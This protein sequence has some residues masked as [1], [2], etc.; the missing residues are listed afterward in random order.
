MKFLPYLLLFLSRAS[1]S[2][3]SEFFNSHYT[4]LLSRRLIS[5]HD[6]IIHQRFDEKTYYSNDENTAPIPIGTNPTSAIVSPTNNTLQFDSILSLGIINNSSN[7]SLTAD[8]A[9]LTAAVGRPTFF[10]NGMEGICVGKLVLAQRGTYVGYSDIA[11]ISCDDVTEASEMIVDY[12]VQSSD[13]VLLYSLNSTSCNLTNAYQEYASQMGFVLTVLSPIATQSILHSLNATNNLTAVITTKSNAHLTPVTNKKNNSTVPIAILYSITGVVAALFL[14]IIISGAIRVHKHPE[15]YGLPPAGGYPEDSNPPSNLYSERAKGLARAVLDSIPLVAVRI[16]HKDGRPTQTCS[17]PL[18]P[19][20]DPGPK[21]TQQGKD[22]E[23]NIISDAK[24]VIETRETAEG[25][26]TA[27]APMNSSN[28]I[29]NTHLESYDSRNN[30]NRNSQLE[31]PQISQPLSH[32]N[33]Q[34]P[35]VPTTLQQVEIEEDDDAMCPICF[36]NF[37]DGQILRILLCKHRFHALCVDPWLL[38]SSSQCPVCRVDL[39]I[40]RNTDQTSNEPSNE[41]STTPPIV[42]PEG[43]EVDTSFF[44]RF[45]DVWNAHLLP[46]EA[47]KAALARFHEEA[48]LRKQL[49]R[50][51]ENTSA[52]TSASTATGHEV[53]QNINNIQEPHN[54]IE[55]SHLWLRFVAS[56]QRLHQLRLSRE[57]NRNNPSTRRNSTNNSN[58]HSLFAPLTNLYHN[59]NHSQDRQSSIDTLPSTNSINPN[60]RTTTP[61]IY[62]NEHSI[63]GLFP[64]ESVLNIVP[65]RSNTPLPIPPLP[66]PRYADTNMENTLA[67]PSSNDNT[68]GQTEDPNNQ[69]VSQDDH[70]ATVSESTGSDVVINESQDVTNPILQPSNA[71]QQDEKEDQNKG[72]DLK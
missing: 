11:F 31:Q 40:Q 3:S 21:P 4:T 25:Q 66:K 59:H 46:R 49:R 18:N 27:N 53:P 41:G 22:I 44:N 70:N 34:T 12:S 52:T 56:R 37:E 54:S 20:P 33:D 23:L 51:R 64:E 5:D 36:E 32:T 10:A 57:N 28:N 60:N 61:S 58:T 30:S 39:S 14:F 29:S 67:S 43:Y 38:N 26:D 35:Y 16:T 62:D 63:S 2:Y 13:C 45:L 17:P 50:R 47:R 6:H 65:D 7:I 55:N 48:E 8:V 15:R 68:N 24:P 19:G 69:T 9:A 42:I 72:K 1:F 71:I